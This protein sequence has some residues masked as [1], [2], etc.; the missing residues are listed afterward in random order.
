LDVWIRN[1]M[2]KKRILFCS[3][4]TFL[5]TG[6]ATYSREILNYLHGTGKY[7]IAEM[8]SYGQRNDPRAANIP[9]KY[10]GVSPNTECEPKASQEEINAFQSNGVNQFGEWIFEHVCLDFMPD[11]V[12][13]IRDFW[14]LEFAERSPFRPYFKWCVMP[15]VD[16]RPQARQWVATYDSADAVLTYSDWA[17]GVLENQSG[18]SIN[19]LG[20]APPSAH[21]A[22]KPVEDKKA[23]KASMGIDPEYKIIGTV[24]RNQRRK[25]YP[26]L[27]AAF[28]KFLDKSENKKYYLYCHTSYP[29]LGWDIPELIQEYGLASHV[30]FTYICPETKKVFPSLF[31]GAVAQSPFTGKWGSTLSNVKNGASYEQLSDIINLFD[32]YTQYANC[33]GFGLPYVEAAACGVP[34]CGTDY[35]AME[36]EMRKLEGFMI[37]PAALYKELETGCLRAVPDN[38]YASEIFLHFFEKISEEDRAAMGK[39][40]R[41]NFEKHFQWHMSGKKWEDYFDSIEVKPI[42]ET[43]ASKPRIHQPAEK[44]E[45][46]ESVN[47][48]QLARWLIVN[49]LG[50]QSKVNSYLEARMSRDLLYRS[51]TGSTGGMY[52][53]E[54]SAAFDGMNHRQPFDFDIAYNQ[55]KSI[56]E[57]RNSWEQRRAE[58]MKQRGLMQ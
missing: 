48:H 10:Y 34:V 46:P 38:E 45:L 14:M 31:H 24:M 22:Y 15:T 8:A 3:E 7:E 26:D 1:K 56:C 6:Y 42:S 44:P 28:R 57:R 19:Y 33:E 29:D 27:F 43:W 54:S 25:L 9:W 50:D 32:L 20:S 16:A 58:T 49:V 51:A 36:S 17:G 52:F 18:G 4:A 2:R 5:N 12:C 37:T 30:L 47:T 40:T 41:E 39:K 23:H 11:V 53:N 21:P 55:M 13:D 35:S